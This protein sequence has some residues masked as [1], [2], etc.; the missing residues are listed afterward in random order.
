MKYCV[1]NGEMFITDKVYLCNCPLCEV[2]HDFVTEIGKY[3]GRLWFMGESSYLLTFCINNFLCVSFFCLC[4]CIVFYICV[5]IAHPPFATRPALL[6][7]TIFMLMQPWIQYGVYFIHYIYFIYSIHSCKW[8]MRFCSN[9]RR[10]K[11]DNDKR[12]GRTAEKVKIFIEP[13]ILL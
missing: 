7:Q 6:S 10:R 11:D 9:F 4:F 3:Y 13:L 5:S 12:P 8:T 1:P 2:Y